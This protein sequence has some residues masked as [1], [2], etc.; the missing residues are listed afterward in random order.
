MNVLLLPSEDGQEFVR[1]ILY[2]EDW[3]VARA[4]DLAI[5]AFTA[6]QAAHPEEWSWDEYE[7]EL[8]AR[9]FI[10]PRWHHGPTWDCEWQP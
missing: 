6:A 8:E 9:G 5:E 3:D 10:I 1:A 4:D 2:P 7:P